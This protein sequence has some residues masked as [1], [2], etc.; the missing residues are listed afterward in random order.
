MESPNLTAYL[1]N[2]AVIST[3]QLIVHSAFSKYCISSSNQLKLDGYEMLNI[4]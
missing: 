3:Q 2:G 4:I 1:S